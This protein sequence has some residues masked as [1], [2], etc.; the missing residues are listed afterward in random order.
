L[1]SIAAE[2]CI[3][4]FEELLVIRCYFVGGIP[5]ASCTGIEDSMESI[6][7]VDRHFS[8]SQFFK[9]FGI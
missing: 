9:C 7:N 2:W 1:L 6:R 8:S 5:R 4:H 3:R